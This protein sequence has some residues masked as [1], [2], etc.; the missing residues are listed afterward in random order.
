MR[1]CPYCME[2]F[3]HPRSYTKFC[4]HECSRKFYNF[5]YALDKKY[6]RD[7]KNKFNES[8]RRRINNKRNNNEEYRL[9]DNLRKKIEKRKR[10]NIFSD[11][12]I[13]IA[14]RGS[15]TLTKHGYRQIICKGHPNARR[16]GG[17]FE[18]VLVMATHLG[19][20]LHSQEN[21]HHKNGIRDDNRIENLELWSRSQ[22]SGQRVEDKIAWAIAFLIE[23]GY[24]II[25]P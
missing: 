6:D 23:C 20:P 10:N 2:E 13:K 22:P 18:H 12:D 21:V 14:P 24:K 5:I 3:F 19:R 25:E 1:Q 17:M 4:S 7:K 8:E 16:D 9:K 15:G 11:E